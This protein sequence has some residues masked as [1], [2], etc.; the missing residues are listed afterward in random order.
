M[1]KKKANPVAALYHTK[2]W[3]R[4]K[5]AIIERAAGTC[6][7]CHKPITERFIVHHMTPATPSNFYDTENLQLLC[8]ACH[9]TVTF[10][11]GV[12]REAADRWEIVE[13]VSEDLL[14]FPPSH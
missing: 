10:V 3:E 1:I 12:M 9:N 14:T 5:H 8:L 13:E 4:T 6:E 11:D 7:R 2:R